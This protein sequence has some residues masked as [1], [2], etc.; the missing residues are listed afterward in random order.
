[1][2]GLTRDAI[3]LN[4]HLPIKWE[5]VIINYGFILMITIYF[6]TVFST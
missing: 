3:S 1:M 4:N 6:K 5:N 2:Y